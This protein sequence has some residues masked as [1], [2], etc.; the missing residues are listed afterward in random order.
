MS[1]A[2]NGKHFEDEVAWFVDVLDTRLK[3]HFNKEC[4]YNDIIEIEPPSLKKVDTIYAN[5]LK[6]FNLNFQERLLL[7]LSIIPSIKPQVLD[8]FF[9]KND[10]FNRGYTEFGGIIN[11]SSGAFIPTIQTCL[12]ILS[13]NSLEKRFEFQFEL[14]ESNNFLL[15]DGIISLQSLENDNSFINKGVY[16]SQEYLDLFTIGVVNKPDF[17]KDFPAKL[18][19]TELDW[20]DLIL[21]SH[22]I[23]Q[24]NEIKIWMKHG[25]TLLHD[26]DLKRKIKPG[27]RSLFFGPPG[28]GKTLTA[29]LLGKST[30]SDVYRIDLSM[31]VSK[32]IGETEKNLSKVFD[33]AEQKGWILFFDEADSLFGKRT[34]IS[35]SHDR[36]ANQEI[37]YLLQRIEDYNGVVILASNMKSNIDDAFTRR[38]QSIIHFPVPRA[39]SRI[40]L[41]NKSFSDVSVF[42]DNV[43][44]SVIAHEHELSGGSIINIVRYCSLMALNRDSVI[45]TKADIESG[46]RKELQKEGK[47]K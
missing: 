6:K 21:E 42:D 27:Y 7:I 9:L 19:S 12:F 3:L 1:I 25:H 22:T 11:P 2:N 46:I 18:I 45:I 15:K 37:S 16:L 23:E 36:Y 43:D 47:T 4:S 44:I 35:D 33:K 34:N 13:G 39:Q 41:W 32:Y 30:G 29:C 26:W 40:K 31:V 8:I 24:I 10:N 20:E 38:F 5:F 17:S 14:F 28:T